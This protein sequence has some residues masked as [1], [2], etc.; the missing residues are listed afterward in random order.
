MAKIKRN[1]MLTGERLTEIDDVKRL[2]ES[3]RQYREGEIT[4]QR[5]ISMAL[6]YVLNNVRPGER[7]VWTW[8]D[9]RM[10]GGG[11]YVEEQSEY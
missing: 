6:Q 11:L 7:I 10:E 9:G 3:T 1:V 2:M 5:A 4:D 8:R